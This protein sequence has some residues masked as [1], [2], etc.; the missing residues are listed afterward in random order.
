MK[1]IR[2]RKA[3]IPFPLFIALVFSSVMLMLMFLSPF[4]ILSETTDF[5]VAEGRSLTASWYSKFM[6]V[7]GYSAKRA[8]EQQVVIEMQRRIRE[9]EQR[10]EDIHA[11]T[12]ITGDAAK[13]PSRISYTGKIKRIEFSDNSTARQA[14]LSMA[15]IASKR[16]KKE[17]K[18]G[19]IIHRTGN[20]TGFMLQN[21]NEVIIFS[22]ASAVD[23]ESAIN[24]LKKLVL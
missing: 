18:D 7:T 14:M 4:F 20:E 16:A 21:N 12:S 6:K 3:F 22:V 17:E 11:G 24:F 8:A 5:K 19:I 10:M 2:G 15:K 23:D 9:E 1:F 13:D